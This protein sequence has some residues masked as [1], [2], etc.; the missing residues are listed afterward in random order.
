MNR[1]NNKGYLLKVFLI[2]S[3]AAAI[4][5][6]CPDSF[7]M[8]G[9]SK[10]RRIWDNIMLFV[11]FGILV[12][13]FIKFAKDPLMNFLRGEE[14]KVKK[15]I[16]A[17]EELVEKANSLMQAEADKLANIDMR[18]KEMREYIIGLGQKEKEKIIEKAQLLARHMIDDAKSEAQYKLEIAKKRFGEEM[19]DIA[20]S[21]AVRELKG[22]LSRDDNEEIVDQFSIVLRAEKIHFA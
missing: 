2:I 16:D 13:V 15:E 11:N 22:R 5:I 3:A 7:A 19:L 14:K 9:P 17:I 10:A 18:I 8:E 12:F 4:F 6:I 1:M 21:I 20:I